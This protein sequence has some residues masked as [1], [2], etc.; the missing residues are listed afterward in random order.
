MKLHQTEVLILENDGHKLANA[1]RQRL[2]NEA[3]RAHLLEDGL[4]LELA[5][6]L[7]PLFGSAQVAQVR[8]VEVYV[9]VEF[10]LQVFGFHIKLS[11]EK[12]D[13]IDLY[14]FFAVANQV[15]FGQEA[16]LVVNDL[17]RHQVVVVWAL[18]ASACCLL[19]LVVGDVVAVGLGVLHLP[20]VSF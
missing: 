14:F 5:H 10:C 13:I 7:L 8:K 15:R 18:L 4:R 19:L 6:V 17:R 1:L 16:A 2:D 20:C 11:S 3:L 9:Q 12:G